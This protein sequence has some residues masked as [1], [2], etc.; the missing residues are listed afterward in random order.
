VIDNAAD[1]SV[2]IGT[3]TV[4]IRSNVARI[5]VAQLLNLTL[6][7][8]APVTSVT[9]GETGR[10]LGYRLT[11]TGNGPEPVRLTLAVALPGNGFDAIARTPSLVLDSDGSQTLTGADTPYTPGSNDPVL[12]ADGSLVVFALLDIPAGLAESSLG[13]TTLA[14]RGLAGSGAPG[15]LF[16]GAGAGGVD[17]LVGLTGNQATATSTLVVSGADLVLEKTATIV[18]AAGGSRA[19]PGAAIRYD[20]KVTASG[21]TPARAVIVRDPIPAATRYVPGSLSLD[22]I[23][24]SDALDGDAGALVATPARV[25]VA[26]GD[27]PPGAVHHVRFSVA[28]N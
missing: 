4:S 6:T 25:E 11:N 22:G 24:L 23:A 13:R 10:A 9:S 2:R 7:P 18:D 3:D 5:V 8:L 12:P 17:A 20:I 19:E 15:T 21:R 16:A 27:L 26:L 1:V 28:I 14:G